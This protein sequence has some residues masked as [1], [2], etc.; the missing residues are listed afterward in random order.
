MVDRNSKSAAPY[1]TNAISECYGRE[2]QVGPPPHP[3][4]FRALA[5]TALFVVATSGSA[6]AA[7]VTP[8]P[9]ATGPVVTGPVAT[10]GSVTTPA[11]TPSLMSVHR[12]GLTRQTVVTRAI[13]AGPSLL[14]REAEHD[15]AEAR[16]DQAIAAFLPRLKVSATYRRVSPL[17]V[18]LGNAA[19][20]G[21]NNA[22]PL[23]VGPVPTGAASNLIV[24]SKGQ[25]IGA[26][27]FKIHSI[28]NQV[29]LKAELGIP[30]S[31]LLLRMR[32]SVGAAKSAAE[33]ARLMQDAEVQ[34]VALDASLAYY[35][36]L[37]AESSLQVSKR[38]LD[39]SRA[40][41]N[42]AKATTRAGVTT[43]LDVLRV[44]ALVA[45][46]EVTV[47][48][49]ERLRA[50]TKRQ[51]QI[52]LDDNRLDPQ[53]GEELQQEVPDSE[54]LS[55]D[56]ATR[57]AQAN[58]LELKALREAVSAAEK[59]QSSYQMARYP[60]LDGF[61]QA[62]QGRPNNAIFVPQDEWRVTWAVGVTL[63]YAPNETIGN[64]AIAAEA[65]ADY[66][67]LQAELESADRNIRLQ[68]TASV[69]DL[70]KSKTQIDAAMRAQQAASDAYQAAQQLYRV[71]EAT[72]TDLLDAETRLLGAELQFIHARI[73]LASAQARL[74][75]AT[76]ADLT[77]PQPRARAQ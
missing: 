13:A 59:R 61:G 53:V 55:D 30:I 18:T 5:T 22:G 47:A 75:H 70:T 76:G 42:D 71:G 50:L 65:R 7:A 45:S 56:E 21:A 48:E 51:L 1:K 38:S 31:D 16:V 46:T 36:F 41:L 44:D 37:R 11:S 60:R 63:S 17:E 32:R 72:T 39:R 4:P 3:R 12:G 67:R 15:A 26:Q 9:V 14:A 58:R 10:G 8:A 24:D 19:I 28:E 73:E 43:N 6:Q 23:F 68:A 29:E 25:P 35:N 54:V 64:G 77:R 27:A 49:A 40:L 20:V 62:I 34:K 66:A 69:L 52:L 74:T 57:R 2:Q 33:A